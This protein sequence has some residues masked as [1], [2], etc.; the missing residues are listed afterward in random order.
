MP[1]VGNSTALKDAIIAENGGV[2]PNGSIPDQ[3]HHLLASNVVI[4]FDAKYS[5]K[6]NKYKKLAFASKY[7]LNAA[8]NGILMPTHFGHQ[9]ELD[10]PRHCGYHYKV[11]FDNIRA[12]LT[13]IYN[14]FKNLNVCKEPFKGNFHAEL[15]SAESTAKSNVKNRTWWL[16]EWSELL[17]VKNYK[18]EGT[19][20]MFAKRGPVTSK[21][22]GLDW[23]AKTTTP[24]RRCLKVKVGNQETI[25]LNT[26]W[27]TNNTYP[28]PG[29]PNS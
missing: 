2:S 16:Y 19:G 5:K 22:A 14:K 29:G 27:Y 3:A 8:P 12:L 20:N 13:P 7:Q 11:Y 26:D 4:E 28:P 24:K 9:E 18:D 10:L 23:A 1:L 6:T 25:V 15:T 17:W 21:N